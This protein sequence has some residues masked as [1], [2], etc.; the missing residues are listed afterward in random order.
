MHTHTPLPLVQV[1]ERGTPWARDL[2]QNTEPSISL[3]CSALP[4]TPT[5]SGWFILRPALIHLLPGYFRLLQPVR[6]SRTSARVPSWTVPSPVFIFYPK[7]R[8]SYL[9][10][11]LLFWEQEE[12]HREQDNRK[13]FLSSSGF[14]KSTFEDIPACSSCCSFSEMFQSGASPQLHL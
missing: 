13:P 2:C 14:S 7:T 1:P 4:P 11:L 8:V 9:K 6:P 10:P 3:S 12:V 5:P